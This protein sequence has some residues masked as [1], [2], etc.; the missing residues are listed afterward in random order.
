M[1]IHLFICSNMFIKHLPSPPYLYGINY[2]VKQKGMEQIKAHLT[3][4]NYI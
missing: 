4:F 1:L 3:V 2:P